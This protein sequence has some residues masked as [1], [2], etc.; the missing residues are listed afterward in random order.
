MKSVREEKA[1]APRERSRSFFA[2]TNIRAPWLKF[3][4]VMLPF[5]LIVIFVSST[6]TVVDNIALP[7]LEA[8]MQK[9]VKTPDRAWRDFTGKKLVALTFDDGPRNTTTPRLLDILKEKNVYVTFFALGSEILKYPDVARREIEEGHEV[10][11]HTMWHQNLARLSEGDLRNDI[12]AANNAFLEVLGYQPSY[13]RPPYGST[14]DLVRKNA[15]APLITWS[16]DTLDWKYRNTESILSHTMST[17]GDGGIILMHDIHPTSVDAVPTL[18]DTLRANGYEFV[19][20][21]E[22]IQKRHATAVNGE[23][24]GKF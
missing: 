18:I 2:R 21:T 22:L 13:I 11:S 24:Y 8:P 10:A 20:L 15:G 7:E 5:L 23:V 9:H 16:V 6:R 3:G 17:I 12:T 1:E 14:S 19:T 4:L